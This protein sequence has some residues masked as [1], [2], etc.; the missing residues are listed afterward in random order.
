MFIATAVDTVPGISI[1]AVLSVCLGAIVKT[2]SATWS[3]ANERGE[4]R[5]D[6][7]KQLTLARKDAQEAHDAT[8]RMRRQRD[9]LW[10]D[11]RRLNPD[12][13]MEELRD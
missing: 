3:L 12:Y 8:W 4:E 1:A 2:F 11:I 6:C 10:S 13:K 7:V 9:Q 5:D